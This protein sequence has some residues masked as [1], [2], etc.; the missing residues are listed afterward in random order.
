MNADSID[1]AEV[2]WNAEVER[3]QVTHGGELVLDEGGRVACWLDYSAADAV[4]RR[5]DPKPVHVPVVW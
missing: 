5:L 2:I 4:K 1:Y 3:W